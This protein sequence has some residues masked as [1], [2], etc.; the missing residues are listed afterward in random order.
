MKSLPHRDVSPLS[1]WSRL[2]A[3]GGLVLVP[4]HLRASTFAGAQ[5]SLLTRAAA[6][7]NRSMGKMMQAPMICTRVSY[8]SCSP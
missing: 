5:S 4:V 8:Y 1:Q 3:S 2:W 7:P 6:T